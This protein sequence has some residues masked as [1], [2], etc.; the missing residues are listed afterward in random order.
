MRALSLLSRLALGTAAFA[1]LAMLAINA[2]GQS[3]IRDTE[4]EE[5]LRE[6]SE[7]LISA[8]GLNKESVDIY[9][10]NDPTLNAFVTR[11][12]KVFFHTGIITEFDSPNQLKGVMAHEIGHISSGHLARSSDVGRSAYG[13]MIVAAAVG[14]AAMLAGEGGAGA[15]ILGSSQQFASLDYLKY[16]RINESSADQAGAQFLEITDQSSEG[17]IE[18]FEKF[19]YQ[20]VMSQSGRFPYFRSH[21]L[22]S[23]RIDSLREVVQESPAFGKKDTDQEIH[24]LTI[25]QAKLRGFI[26]PPQTTFINYPPEDISEAARIAR[27]VAHFRNADLVNALREI[28]SLIREFPDNPYNYELKGQILYES[29]KAEEALPA[30][31]KA[32]ALKPEAALLEM[33]LGQAL[34][35]TRPVGDL[36]AE[37]LTEGVALLKSTLQKEPG[38]GTAWYLLSQAYSEQGNKPLA[39]YAVA[40][41]AYAIGDLRRA[42]EFASRALEDLPKGTPD[43]RRA[44]DIS[45]ITRAN[46][47]DS[48]SRRR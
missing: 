32:T 25:A 4:I 29:G 48:Q 20:E 47:Q 12:Q 26:D 43:Y 14:I 33:A 21:P 39:K 17:L 34:I 36:R 42:Q 28:E 41:Q 2:S 40:E 10:V 46:L 37:R 44:N 30:L 8:A 45:V 24:K 18:F 31:R 27:S 23:S 5:I 38:N 19:R 7:P 6:F 9:I 13:T 11:G 3:L 22:S 1:M 16:S 15:A 35:S